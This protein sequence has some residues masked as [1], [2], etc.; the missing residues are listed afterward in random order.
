MI[1]FDIPIS[2]F[3]SKLFFN[4]VKINW[5]GN[6]PIYKLSFSRRFFQLCINL[7]NLKKLCFIKDL[8]ILIIVDLFNCVSV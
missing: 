8:Q 6:C 1:P 5:F 3:E 4:E 7:R 2:S